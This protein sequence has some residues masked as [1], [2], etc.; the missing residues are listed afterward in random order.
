MRGRL[1]DHGRPIAT[2]EIVEVYRGGSRARID[3]DLSSSIGP[4]TA[5]EIDL[6]TAGGP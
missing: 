4:S 3:G 1:V 5:V 6:P 2:I